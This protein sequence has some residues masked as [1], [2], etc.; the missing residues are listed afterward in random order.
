MHER[1][2]PLVRIGDAHALEDLCDLV[3]VVASIETKNAGDLKRGLKKVEALS[4]FYT[5]SQQIS[6][7]LQFVADQQDQQQKRIKLIRSGL[8]VRRQRFLRSFETE[9]LINRRSAGKSRGISTNHRYRNRDR[10]PKYKSL[11]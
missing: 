4:S 3:E 7:I 5:E 1:L 8:D 10:E 6:E 9:R 11:G 2:D